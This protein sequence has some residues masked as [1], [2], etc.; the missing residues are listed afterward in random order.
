MAGFDIR[1]MMNDIEEAPGKVWFWDLEKAV[2]DADRCVQCGACVAACPTDSIGIADDDLPTLVKMCTGCSLCWD[3]C[4]RGGLRHEATWK[5]EDPEVPDS[6]EGLFRKETEEEEADASLRRLEDQNLEKITGDNAAAARAKGFG[7]LEGVSGTGLGTVRETY[8][9]RV[10]RDI[11]GVQ[12]GGVVSALLISL[13]EKGEIDGALLA[14]ESETTPWKGEAYLATTPEEVIECAGSFYNQTLALG[15]LDLSGYSLPPNPRI[16][17]VGTPCETEAI[18][19]MQARPWSWGSSNVEAVTLTVALL[20]TK[21][22]DY[23]KLMVEEVS[24]RRGVPLSDIGRVDIIRGKFI[25]QGHDG[26]TIFEEPIKN[27]HGAALKGCDECADFMGHAAD[28]SVGSVGSADGYSSVLV[29]S[30]EGAFA[31]EA[32]REKLELRELDKPEALD[33][34]DGLDKRIAFKTLAREFDP[35]APLFIDFE[36]HLANYRGTDRA[37]VEHDAVRY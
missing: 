34:L 20:C 15:H 9:A 27:F 37:P 2:I 18:K 12:D 23:E 29:R 14:R 22:F 6:A 35:D 1:D 30:E 33:K 26:G 28:I 10:K 31:F 11:P 13:L 17:V 25:V 5:L 4:P 3:F 32:V 24:E 7:L 36:E 19:A 21:S 8:T 16:A